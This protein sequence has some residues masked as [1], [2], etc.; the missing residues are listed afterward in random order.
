MIVVCTA[1]QYFIFL[2]TITDKSARL[3]VRTR[4]CTHVSITV[5]K[6]TFT[7]YVWFYV[8]SQDITVL[9]CFYF[10]TALRE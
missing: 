7:Y 10:S 9:N 4:A 5:V 6:L 2:F 8:H 1:I 3:L